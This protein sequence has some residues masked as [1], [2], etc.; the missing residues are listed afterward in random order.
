MNR[1]FVGDNM[2]STNAE[3][4]PENSQQV[5]I[6]TLLRLIEKSDT[7][8][9]KMER[10][11]LIIIAFLI[12]VPIVYVV[13][14]LFGNALIQAKIALLGDFF[15]PSV[16]I[17]F[18]IFLTVIAYLIQR[19]ML[20]RKEIKSWQEHLQKLHRNAENLLSKL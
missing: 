2:S 17:G 7:W 1:F 3:S 6:E 15:I 19:H 4:E 13:S 18:I 10:D 14:A 11:S 5:T 20:I 12:I 16:I 8:L 9:R